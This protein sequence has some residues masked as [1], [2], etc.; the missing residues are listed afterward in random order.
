[1][2]KGV[3]KFRRIGEYFFIKVRNGNGTGGSDITISGP[4]GNTTIHAQTGAQNGGQVYVVWN[5][6]TL[7]AY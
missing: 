3:L 6:S 7:T 1:M 2:S 4:S 5:G